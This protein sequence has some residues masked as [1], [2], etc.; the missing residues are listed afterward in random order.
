MAKTKTVKRIRP[1]EMAE[2]LVEFNNKVIMLL[3]SCDFVMNHGNVNEAIKS[4]FKNSID[5]VREFYN[6]E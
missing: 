5:E 4:N 3:Q 1:S 6:A 2:S